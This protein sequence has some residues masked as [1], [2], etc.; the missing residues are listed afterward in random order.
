[1][2][3]VTVLSRAG[4][5]RVRVRPRRGRR[6]ALA[7]WQG[8]V[9]A[10]SHT[11]PN[12][13]GLELFSCD[14]SAAS[15]HFVARLAHSDSPHSRWACPRADPPSPRPSRS[16]SGRGAALAK[17]QGRVSAVSHTRRT[18][19]HEPRYQYTAIWYYCWASCRTCF[20]QTA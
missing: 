6:A 14:F 18:S 20:P 12:H 15:P 10:V 2:P 19:L 8:R 11:C 13:S 17:W 5:A 4:L 7:S 16:A 1:M 9:C 3:A